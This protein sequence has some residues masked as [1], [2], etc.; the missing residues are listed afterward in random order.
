MSGLRGCFGL[1]R[2]RD[3][4]NHYGPTETHDRCR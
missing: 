4:I 3:F 1:G 2:A